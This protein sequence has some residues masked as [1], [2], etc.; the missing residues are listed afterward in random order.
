MM[1]NQMRSTRTTRTITT[2]RASTARAPSP[3]PSHRA[4]LVR[5]AKRGGDRSTPGPLRALPSGLDI[6]D[7]GAMAECVA[8]LGD[9]TGSGKGLGG[10]NLILGLG[11]FAGSAA[12]LQLVSDPEKRR[13]L[14]TDEAGG[15]ELKSVGDYF[16]GEGFQRWRRIYDESSEDVN[17]VQKDIR[18]GHA[19]TIDIAL[20]WLTGRG[21]ELEG[22]TV[23]DAGCGTGS[24]AVPLALKGAKVSASDISSAMV[25]EA[26]RRYDLAAA[27]NPKAVKPTFEAKDLESV[28]GKYNTVTCLDVVIH[29]PDSKMAGMIKH[30]TDCAE[31][32]VIMSFAPKTPYY[33]FLK[34]VGELFPGKSK[35]TRAYLHAEEDI[36]ATFNRLGWK[37]VKRD[38]TATSFYFS[39][40][41]EAVRV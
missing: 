4:S 6:N 16:E 38:M 34:R 29:Y 7:L 40:I 27:N 21:S 12:V 25:E 20:D 23:C 13:Q 18:D 2:T 15:D 39:R 10:L 35:A 5:L 26:G 19:Q 9:A 37:I 36:E 32:R 11:A 17:K 41:V 30:L 24:L 1:T 8:D 33:S 14:M 28:S 31:D 22:M 3:S